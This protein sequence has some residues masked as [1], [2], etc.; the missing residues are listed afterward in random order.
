VKGSRYVNLRWVLAAALLPLLLAGLFALAVEIQAL[1]RYD[2]AYFT[3]TY[4][5]RYDTPGSVARVLERA[6]QSDDR[7]LLAELQGLR[8]PASFQTSPDLIF[9]MLW[10]R[11]DRY[12]SYLYFDMQTY[13][14]HMYYFEQVGERWV[15]TPPD[16]WYYL[17]S[18]RWLGVFLPVAI[19]WWLVQAVVVLVVLVFR[20]SARLRELRYGG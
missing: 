10:E 18:G 19:T 15:V 6:L 20:L 9:V 5:E 1:R 13:E 7:M 2:P 16:A 17:H 11:G 8:R 12:I 4:V 14:R 3:I